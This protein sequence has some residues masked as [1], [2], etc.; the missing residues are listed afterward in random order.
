M[1]KLAPIVL[2]TYNRLWHT[3]QTVEALQ[4]N[5]L[6]QKSQLFIYSDA[7]KTQVAE[8][9]VKEVRQYLKTINGFKKVTII[10]RDKN[11]GLAN[12]IIDGVTKIVNEYGKVIVLEDDLVT[13]PYFLQ[14][15]NEALTFYHNQKPVWHISGYQF[16]IYTDNLPET[17]FF[18]APSSWGWATWDYAWKLFERDIEKLDKLFTKELRYQFNLEGTKKFWSHIEANKSGKMNTWA[19]FWYASIFLNKGLCLYPRHSLVQNIGHD[20]S[21]VHSK[22]PNGYQITLAKKPTEFFDTHIQEHPEF[23]QRI[24]SF[25]KYKKF[26]TMKRIVKKIFRLGQK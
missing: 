24:K 5:Y 14:F 11:W 19:I 15:M 7:Q 13:S 2:F 10:E 4:K 8:A 22:D 9:K 25:F 17:I 6:A 18:R 16:P 23:F 3:R 12:S 21:G 1:S 20:G 26:N